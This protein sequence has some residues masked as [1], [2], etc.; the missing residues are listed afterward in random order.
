MATMQLTR[1]WYFLI[2]SYIPMQCIMYVSLGLWII[3]LLNFIA[4]HPV[5][6]D[7]IF[8][9]QEVN[10]K[11]VSGRLVVACFLLNSLI[12]ATSLWAIV[13]RTKLCLDFSSTAFFLHLVASLIYNSGWPYSASW[14]VLQFSCVTITCVLAEFLCMRSEMK[15]IPL[16]MSAKVDL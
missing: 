9:Y 13:Q 16:G 5:S 12:S 15:S 11:D 2:I 4:G 1:F 3:V 10:V 6:I 7:Y 8:K 14:W